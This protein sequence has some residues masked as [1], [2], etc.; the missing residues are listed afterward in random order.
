MT[1][2]TSSTKS[3]GPVS[4]GDRAPDFTLPDQNG[5]PLHFADYLG[6]SSI[7][8]FF[9]P[10]DN[11]AV[12]T[13]EACAF[14]DRYEVFRDAGA[15]V[16][17]VSNDSS[18]SHAGFADQHRLPFTLLSDAK[19]QVRSLYGAKFL[20]LLPGR[21]TYIIDKAGIIRHTFSAMMD[22]PKHVAEALRILKEIADAD[23]QL[24][25]AR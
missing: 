19:G 9:Y 12:C 16:I 24:S 4:I 21:T 14:R 20:G 8:L 25:N 17:G 1:T 7:V 22:G 2:R 6:K 11:S 15:V 5:K 18:E 3:G 10:K 23:K 13:A